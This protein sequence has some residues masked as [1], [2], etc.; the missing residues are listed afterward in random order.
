M[1]PEKPK[2]TKKTKDKSQDE[3]EVSPK[4]KPKKKKDLPPLPDPPQLLV[5]PED[6]DVATR[7]RKAGMAV[8]PEILKANVLNAKTIEDKLDAIVE[9]EKKMAIPALAKDLDEFW[10]ANKLDAV[11]ELCVLGI[12]L[13][14]VGTV[15]HEYMSKKPIHDLTGLESLTGLHDEVKKLLDDYKKYLPLQRAFLDLIKDNDIQ[16]T[17]ALDG[18]EFRFENAVIVSLYKKDDDSM[19]AYM[20][21]KEADDPRIPGTYC[22]GIKAVLDVLPPQ[23]KKDVQIRGMAIAFEKASLM[24]KSIDKLITKLFKKVGY[25]FDPKKIMEAYNEQNE[26]EQEAFFKEKREKEKETMGK[27]EKK[28]KKEKTGKEKDG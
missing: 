19:R 20:K 21:P 24:F 5:E 17:V 18:L 12:D 10:N 27:K 22:N 26:R 25:D 13:F 4:E 11:K 28:G 15:A 8:K 16:Q 2:K 1:E 7:P 23:K 14:K 3:S 6:A 9:L